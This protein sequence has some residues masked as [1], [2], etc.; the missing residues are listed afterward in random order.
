MFAFHPSPCQ[1]GAPPVGVLSTPSFHLQWQ[2]LDSLFSPSQLQACKHVLLGFLKASLLSSNTTPR[3]KSAQPDPEQCFCFQSRVAFQH[4]VMSVSWQQGLC[5]P[6]TKDR[7]PDLAHIQKGSA[8]IQML[9]STGSQRKS[10]H[11]SG[12]PVNLLPGFCPSLS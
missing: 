8:V 12:T 5:L 1:C 3:T 4:L 11:I 2:G 7:A 10:V 9:G 6:N